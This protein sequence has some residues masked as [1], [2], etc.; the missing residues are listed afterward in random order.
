MWR[1]ISFEGGWTRFAFEKASKRERLD[2][3]TVNCAV[4]V[5]MA[6]DGTIAAARYSAGGVAATPLRL[7]DAEKAMIGRKP[8]AAL[9]REVGALAA[10]AGSPMSDVRGSSTYRKRLLERLAWAAFTRL[11]PE[12]KLEE[13]LLA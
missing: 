6:A 11:W 12:L 8:S 5:R 13:E 1:A 4:A 2:I 3:A 9:A 10:A 7:L